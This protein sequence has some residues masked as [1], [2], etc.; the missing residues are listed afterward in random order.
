VSPTAT[1]LAALGVCILAFG[2]G[3]YAGHRQ[4]PPASPLPTSR[5]V[6]QLLQ[7]TLTT[8]TGQAV[9]LPQQPGKIQVINFWATWCPPCRR[10]MP[11]FS[12]L[13]EELQASGVQFSGIAIDSAENVREFSHQNRISYPLYIAPPATAALLTELG[14]PGGALPYTLIIDRQGQPRHATLGQ[15]SGPELTRLLQPLL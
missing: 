7:Q 3:L 4:A 11:E 5:S 15:I 1:R 14:N 12:R 10:E 8:P 9:S 6:E 2:L 13:Q